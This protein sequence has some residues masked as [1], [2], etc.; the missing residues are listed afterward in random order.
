[1]ICRL[2][3]PPTKF[4][5]LISFGEEF[6][7]DRKIKVAP[8]RTHAAIENILTNRSKVRRK[9][10]C[11]HMHVHRVFIFVSVRI[12]RAVHCAAYRRTKWQSVYQSIVC[13]FKHRHKSAETVLKWRHFLKGCLY[14]DF[15]LLD[16]VR[17]KIK[18][19][20]LISVVWFWSLHLAGSP[21]QGVVRFSLI[22]FE[23]TETDRILLEWES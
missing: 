11:V 2:H 19:D 9:H 18:I 10:T 23:E 8:T 21:K 5:A 13:Q 7:V 14:L 20:N 4:V 16:K 12:Q 22:L 17:S 3:H 15:H 1:M 6:K